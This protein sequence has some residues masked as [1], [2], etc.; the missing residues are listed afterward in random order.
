MSTQSVG[1]LE[2][3]KPKEGSHS[4]KTKLENILDRL[5]MKHVGIFYGHYKYLRQF[6]IFHDYSVYFVVIWYIFTRF[7]KKNM[8]S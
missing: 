3:T 6:G 8:L 2:S 4:K 1:I 7:T 5:G